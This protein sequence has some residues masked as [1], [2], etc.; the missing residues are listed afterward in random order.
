VVGVTDNYGRIL[1]FLDRSHYFSIKN[2]E[3]LMDASKEIDLEINV[4]KTKYMLLYCHQN[5]R[6]N[7][8]INIANRSFQMWHSS[9]IWDRQRQTKM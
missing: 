4:K 5:V 7:H 8:D 6:P 3:T 9:N 2:T 1:G